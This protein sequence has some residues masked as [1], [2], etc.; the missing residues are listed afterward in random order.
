MIAVVQRVSRASVTVDAK[1]VGQI[2]VGLC[3]L[4]AIEK[5]DDV[6]Q[7]ERMADKLV[8]LRIFRSEDGSK[9]FDRDV[10]QVNGQILLVSNFTVS[11]ST[12]KG[13]RPTLEAAADPETGR[14]MFDQ[15]IEKVK[16]LGVPVSTGTFQADMLVSIDNNGPATF[17]VSSRANVDQE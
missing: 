17:I 8:H 13:R 5:G 1:V 3:A 11:A 14:A 12:R 16:S 10:M 15:L 2:D 7:I 4:V 6:D 9:H